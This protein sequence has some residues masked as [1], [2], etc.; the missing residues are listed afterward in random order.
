ML[1]KRYCTLHCSLY[2]RRYCPLLPR[3]GKG[4]RPAILLSRPHNS[5]VCTWGTFSLIRFA[6]RLSLLSV[7]QHRFLS[8]LIILAIGCKRLQLILLISTHNNSFIFSFL[9][10]SIHLLESL[11]GAYRVVA[12]KFEFQGRIEFGSGTFLVAVCE[13]RHS[14]MV[15]KGCAIGDLLNALAQQG[16]RVAI[17]P[18]QVIDPRE[19]IADAREFGE[20]L[21]GVLCQAQCHVQIASLKHIYPCEI[22]IG[23]P[24]VRVGG[25]GGLVILPRRAQ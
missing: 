10:W 18:F 4:P 19:S 5:R 8:R 24:G 25:Q 15:T 13:L 20:L 3:R 2:I 17:V 16:K 9:T 22:G 7:V 6:V 12:R 23:Q 21:L 1:N 11:S 14:E